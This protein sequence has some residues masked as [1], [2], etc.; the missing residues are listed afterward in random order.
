MDFSYNDF[1]REFWEDNLSG[2]VPEKLYDIHAHLWTLEGQ[3]QLPAEKSSI[4]PEIDFDGLREWGCKLFPE[5]EVH[6][7]IL[8]TPLPGMDVENHNS[9]LAEQVKSDPDSVGGMLITPGTTQE[10]LEYGFGK[11]GFDAVKPYRLFAKDPKNADITDFLPESLLEVI[12]SHGKAVMLHLSKPEGADNQKN[13]DDLRYFTRKYPEIKWILAHCA[14]AFNPLFLEKSIHNLKYIPN[15]WYGTSAVNNLY[16]HYLLLKHE[17]INRIM[18]GS[19]NVLAGCS[20]GKYISYARAWQYYRGQENLEHCDSRATLVIYEQ[21]LQQ[22]RA[23]EML[24]L[25]SSDIDKL[26]FEN[27]QNLIRNLK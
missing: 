1:D 9:W 4:H 18:F 19:D 12:N 20:R 13:L 14:R 27:A 10:E 3:D 11:L 7:L 6:F 16:S 8:G 15:L 22:K 2:F 5:R 17:C 21:L 25:S 23:A 24:E 26:F